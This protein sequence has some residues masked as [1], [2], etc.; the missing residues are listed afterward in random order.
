MMEGRG[1][2]LV[3]SRVVSFPTS[4]QTAHLYLLQQM[5]LLGFFLPPYAAVFRTHV[6]S[7]ELHRDPADLLRDSPPTKLQHRGSRIVLRLR[8]P[9]FYSKYTNTFFMSTSHH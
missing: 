8:G 5:A 9:G 7:V 1:G 2:T 4:S 3:V 6:S